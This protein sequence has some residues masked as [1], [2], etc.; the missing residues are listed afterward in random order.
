MFFKGE[1][2]LQFRTCTIKLYNLLITIAEQ[3]Y[4]ISHNLKISVSIHAL[5]ARQSLSKLTFIGKY[6]SCKHRG[7]VSSEREMS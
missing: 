4:F 3:L 5:E 2:H 6:C 7:T 1:V